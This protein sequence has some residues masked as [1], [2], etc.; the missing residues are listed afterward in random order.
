MRH[1]RNRSTPGRTLVVAVALR[2]ARGRA[3]GLRRDGGR[4]RLPRTRR[5]PR[6]S[7]RR[8]APYHGSRHGGTRSHPTPAP[9]G[10]LVIVTP[11][12]VAGR[13]RV[14]ASTATRSTL[15]AGAEVTGVRPGDGR[16]GRQRRPS[17]PTAPMVDQFPR[18]GQRLAFITVR[19]H[20]P[21]PRRLRGGRPREGR[22]ASTAAPRRSPTSATS[23]IDGAPG[24]G[25]GVRLPGPPRLRG[26]DGPRR[27]RPDREA[28]HAAAR[29]APP[30]RRPPW[31]TSCGSSSPSC[32]A[33]DHDRPPVAQPQVRPASRKAAMFAQGTSGSSM[34]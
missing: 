2:C 24:E 34:S 29:R 3:C 15:P 17:A 4:P 7:A 32:G 10:Q 14:A 16:L 28:D 19:A 23:L 33:S 12:P 8:R 9:T 18:T 30:S 1:A 13:V 22:A 6:P 21:R 11:P 31:R 5:P 27:D 20:R 26:D 25:R